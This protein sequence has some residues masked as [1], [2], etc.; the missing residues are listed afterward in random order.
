MAQSIL[1]RDGSLEIFI[2]SGVVIGG[3]M[4]VVNSGD[5]LGIYVGGL[6]YF[7]VTPKDIRGNIETTEPIAPM[8]A[9]LAKREGLELKLTNLKLSKIKGGKRVRAWRWKKP[10]MIDDTRLITGN[11][12]RDVS[13]NS[14]AYGGIFE[15]PRVNV[16][17]EMYATYQTTVRTDG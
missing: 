12:I 17:N 11:A 14:G 13:G 1:T 2:S 9:Y 16:F 6:L 10:V 7:K 15:Y 3:D 5:V 8:L 4:T